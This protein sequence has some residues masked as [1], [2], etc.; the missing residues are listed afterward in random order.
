VMFDT[1]FVYT[2]TRVGTVFISKDFSFGIS[3]KR[4][5]KMVKKARL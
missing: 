5:T 2:T 4:Y 3:I 1:S